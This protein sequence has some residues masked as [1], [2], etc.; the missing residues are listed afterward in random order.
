MAKLP[1]GEAG[2][3]G[4][5]LI[6]SQVYVPDS[7]S[8]GQHMHDAAVEMVRRGWNVVVYTSARGYEDSTQRFAKR[9]ILNGVDIRRLPLS[10]FGKSN[11]PVR[12]LGGFIFL[13]QAIF[14]GLFVRNVRHLLI[15]TSP[16]MCSIAGLALGAIKRASVSF[17]AMD[18]NPDQMVALGKLGAT[19]F[20]VRVFD[21]LNARILQR[22]KNI[23]ALDCYMAERLN[24][25][26][27]ISEKVSIIPPWPHFDQDVEPLKH[28]DNP[29]REKY[30]L[31]NRF[32]VMYSG[33][34][35]TSHPVDTIL[36]AAKR[37]GDRRDILFLFI[38][39]GNGRKA[40]EVFIAETGASNIKLLPYQPLSELRYSLSA[41]D[42]HLVA[43]GESMV[44]IVHPCKIYGAMAVGRPILLLGP[45][46]SHAGDILAKH[47][48]GWHIE[49]GEVDK[50]VGVITEMASTAKD[51][52]A[53]FGDRAREVANT[54]FSK[55]ALV[56]EF[57]DVLDHE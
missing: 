20:P 24:R 52:L 7:P 2:S 28:K 43:V 14:R 40:I 35:S 1:Q 48:I 38:G 22:S 39:G 42:V 44:G 9:E 27:P 29:F 13:G 26:F 49:H 5:L 46:R 30:G 4:T 45:T 25:K 34:L 3:R 54:E 55:R 53:A 11:V 8:V 23:I 51:T 32:V 41:A 47:D 16:P 12:L 6:I 36:E 17:W 50:T 19:S 18:I 57:C 21:W 15:S 33:N 56:S 31:R 10:S 37:L